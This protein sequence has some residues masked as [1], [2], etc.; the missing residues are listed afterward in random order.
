MVVYTDGLTEARGPEGS[1]GDDGLMAMLA[2]MSDRG[3]GDMARA[4]VDRVVAFQ[5][6]T[7]RDDIA[8]LVVT[9]PL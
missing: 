9:M 3:A 8:V 4:L 1:L 6:G 5:D 2:T 7:P